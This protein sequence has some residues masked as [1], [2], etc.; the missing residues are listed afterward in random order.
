MNLVQGN[1]IPDRLSQLNNNSGNSLPIALKMFIGQYQV[2]WGALTAGSMVTS[3]L[4]A[5]FLMLV[6]RYL[7]AGLTA[8][9][10][11]Q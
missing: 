1:N 8:G 4:L 11:K 9:A 7:I 6:Q 5:I 2:D 10:V 3:V